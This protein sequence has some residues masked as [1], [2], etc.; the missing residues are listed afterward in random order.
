M[1]NSLITD[2]SKVGETQYSFYNAPE[3]KNKGEVR[4]HDKNFWL[5]QKA[6]AGLFDVNVLAVSKHLKN[7][8][9]SGE[10]DKNPVCAKFAHTAADGKFDF[11][12]R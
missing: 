12:H 11:V 4:F 10:S 9:E 5:T 3:G 1:Q 8:F 2:G 6:L 7:T